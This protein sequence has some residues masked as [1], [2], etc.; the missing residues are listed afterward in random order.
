MTDIQQTNSRKNGSSR[1]DILDAAQR[2]AG[3]EGAA[4]LTLE[5]VAKECGL[6]KGGLL[7]NFRSKDALLEGMMERLLEQNEAMMASESSA[8]E[9]EKNVTVRSLL[10]CIACHQTADPQVYLSIIAA[11]VQ[12]PELLEPIKEKLSRYYEEMVKESSDPTMTL[13]LW[14][15]A[16]GLLLHNVL[17][18]APYS[19]AT[20]NE[21]F[22]RLL[23]LSEE[24]T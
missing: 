23:S 4:N 15:A 1:D 9:G 22:Q 5:K 24:L 12:S 8:L 14:A 7:Y 19:N 16:D 10:R 6:S 18:I 17:G 13:L 21:L 20:R 2:V 3:R 11:S